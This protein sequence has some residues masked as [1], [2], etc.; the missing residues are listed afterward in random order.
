MCF[1]AMTLGIRSLCGT[2]VVPVVRSKELNL[3]HEGKTVKLAGD[4]TYDRTKMQMVTV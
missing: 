2:L 4:E 3:I 1:P